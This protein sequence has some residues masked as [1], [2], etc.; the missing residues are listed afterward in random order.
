M[1]FAVYGNFEQSHP[2]WYQVD[3]DH[4]AM[5]AMA[6]RSLAE[7]GK[8]RP[9]MLCYVGENDSN[10]RLVAGFKETCRFH[11]G[12][13]ADVDMIVRIGADEQTA[14]IFTEHF[15]RWMTRPQSHRP[16]SIVIAVETQ[17][18][19]HIEEQIWRY[20]KTIGYKPDEFGMSGACYDGGALAAWRLLYV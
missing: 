9:A 4:H 16:D 10:D 12:P 1:K 18:L 2:N 11:H 5:M 13:D 8:V 15:D 20:G 14:R 7:R 3:F 19:A 17:S 6:V